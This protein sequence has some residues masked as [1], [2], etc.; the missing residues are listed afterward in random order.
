[1]RG[2]TVAKM[3]EMIRPFTLIMMFAFASAKLTRS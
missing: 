3:I 1:M 2:E